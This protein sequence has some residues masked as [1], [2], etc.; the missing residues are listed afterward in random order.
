MHSVLSCQMVW[1]A[2]LATEQAQCLLSPSQLCL[3]TRSEQTS[4]P[5][6]PLLEGFWTTVPGQGVQGILTSNVRSWRKKSFKKNFTSFLCLNLIYKRLTKHILSLSLAFSLGQASCR[7]PH[8]IHRKARILS[9]S[10][11]LSSL[12]LQLSRNHSAGEILLY[13][14]VHV[15]FTTMYVISIIFPL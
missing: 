2:S 9:P 10:S 4:V 6:R 8:F 7:S 13:I 3:Q 14:Q 12:F 5:K 11:L 15:I 1:K